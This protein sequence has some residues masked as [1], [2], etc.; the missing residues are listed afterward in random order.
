LSATA[1]YSKSNITNSGT[2]YIDG[3]KTYDG[4]LITVATGIT[5]SSGADIIIGGS[6]NDIIFG[7]SG[8]DTITSGAG[9]DFITVGN[10]YTDTIITDFNP[11]LDKLTIT[12]PILDG[13]NLVYPIAH[14]YVYASGTENG[15]MRA[16]Q[17]RGYLYIDGSTTTNA[18]NITGSNFLVEPIPSSGGKDSIV[19]GSGNDTITG[20]SGID[21]L[22]GGAGV[23]TFVFGTNDSPYDSPDS[24]TD[25]TSGD[26]IRFAGKVVIN[27]HTITDNQA[28]ILFSVDAYGFPTFNSPVST[29]SDKLSFLQ[30]SDKTKE[31]QTVTLFVD[32]SDTYVFFAG[33]N[34][35]ITDIKADDQVIKLTGVSGRFFDAITINPNETDI[36]IS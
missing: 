24:I 27:K 34:Q 36:T 28:K 30:T 3:S 32:G 5:G 35:G 26:L 21:T 18:K 8:N 23:D 1:D 29:Y 6:G 17:N 33:S 31:A 11:I 16:V 19:G 22:T 4:T 2:L 13:N 14:V 9:N 20:G 25:F 15:D 12:G 7:F 10:L